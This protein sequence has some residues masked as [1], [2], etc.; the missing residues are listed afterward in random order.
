VS[1]WLWLY[2]LLTVALTALV[3]VAWRRLSVKEDSGSV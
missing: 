3:M 2:G 1:H